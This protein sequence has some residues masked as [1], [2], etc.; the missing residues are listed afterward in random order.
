M[1]PELSAALDPPDRDEIY[2]WPDMEA[3]VA[4]FF[5]MS[6]QWRWVGAGMGGLL[7]TGL[8][9][10][11]LPSLASALEI[12]TTADVLNDLRTLEAAAVEQWGRK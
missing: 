5:A 1:P 9:Y 8:D 3:A 10:S 11:V 7:R 12:E 6:T 4:L 2:V